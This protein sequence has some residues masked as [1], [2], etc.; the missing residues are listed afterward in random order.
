MRLHRLK[1]RIEDALACGST[2]VP[3]SIEESEEYRSLLRDVEVN[4]LC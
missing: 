4:M 1:K 3:K 2:E